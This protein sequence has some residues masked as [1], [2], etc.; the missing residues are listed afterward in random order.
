MR[1]IGEAALIESACPNMG[2]PPLTM[3]EW[4]GKR[5]RV[6]EYAYLKNIGNG[7]AI[8]MNSGEVYEETENVEHLFCPT[9]T[10]ST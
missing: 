7:L 3:W 10:A 8:R 4:K 1:K 6:S 5:V 2:G 9:N